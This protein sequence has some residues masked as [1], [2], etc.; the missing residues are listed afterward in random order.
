MSLNPE[1]FK[2]YYWVYQSIEIDSVKYVQ[3]V[4]FTSKNNYFPKAISLTNLKDK[5]YPGGLKNELVIFMIDG[6]IVRG[7]CDTYEIDENN[8]Y[9]ITAD[10]QNSKDDKIKFQ[11]LK[12]TTKS[13]PN[14][15]NQ[16]ARKN[17]PWAR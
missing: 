16:N 11:F 4:R 9:S 12:L 2:S 6:L 10:L 1:H 15:K 17:N 14:F 8:L 5:Y 3:Q 13:D 7:D